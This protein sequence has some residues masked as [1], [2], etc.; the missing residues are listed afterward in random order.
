VDS[1]HSQIKSGDLD[2]TPEQLFANF[3]AQGIMDILTE[4]PSISFFVVPSISDILSEH[5]SFPQSELDTSL[6]FHNVR[7]GGMLE[8]IL[9]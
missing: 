1:S 2:E 7:V 8:S 4:K 6:L 3:F 9:C 5:T